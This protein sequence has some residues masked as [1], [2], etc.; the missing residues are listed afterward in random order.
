VPKLVQQV[1]LSPENTRLQEILIWRLWRTQK[2]VSIRFEKQCVM[3][4]K[5]RKDVVLPD[6]RLCFR[7]LSAYYCVYSAE[8]GPCRGSHE[9]FYYDASTKQCKQFIYGGCRGNKNNFRQMHDCKAT[10]GDIE[11]SNKKRK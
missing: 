6:F 8:K 10:C 7:V 5:I 2:Y 9:R 4:R 11:K 1:S 3:E